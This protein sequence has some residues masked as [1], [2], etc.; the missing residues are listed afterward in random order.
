MSHLQDGLQSPTEKFK[1]GELFEIYIKKQLRKRNL[2]E[3]FA[4]LHFRI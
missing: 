1:R 2:Q 3:R 4:T